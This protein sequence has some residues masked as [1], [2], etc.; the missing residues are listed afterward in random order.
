MI[1]INPMRWIELGRSALQL[2]I[3][4]QLA[5]LGFLVAG[6]VYGDRGFVHSARRGFYVI[7]AALTVSTV[8]LAAAFLSRACYDV[9][10]IAMHSST[11]QEWFYQLAG[12]WA[13]QEGSI[14]F[15]TWI[16]SL[17]GAALAFSLRRDET[18]KMP[19]VLAV[20]AMVQLYF[21]CIVMLLDQNPFKLVPMD[22]LTSAIL[23]LH[24]TEI[25]TGNDLLAWLSLQV[26]GGP[27]APTYRALLSSET[28]ASI[29]AVGG[30]LLP[31]NLSAASVA[32]MVAEKAHAYGFSVLPDGRGLNPLLA[33]YWI[34]IH[35]PAM[36]TGYIGTTVLFAFAIASLIVGEFDGWIKNVRRWLLFCWLFLSVGNILGG[37]WAYEELGWGGFWDWDPVENAAFVPWLTATAMLHTVAA[38]ENRGGFRV[39]NVVLAVMTFALTIWGTWVT[40]S[41]AIASVHAFADG[42]V[43]GA[44]LLGAVGVVIAG[45]TWLIVHRWPELRGTATTATTHR[46][47]Q[48]IWARETMMLGGAITFLIILA[49]V[50]GLTLWPLLTW[51]MDGTS[52]NTR[53]TF[54][55]TTPFFVL[56]FMLMGAATALSWRREKPEA[57]ESKLFLPAMIGA[58]VA[59]LT[60]ALQFQFSDLNWNEFSANVSLGVWNNA[61][62]RALVL[63]LIPPAVWGTTVFVLITTYMEFHRPAVLRARK[64]AGR[65]EAAA[66][67]ATPTPTAVPGYA[68]TEASENSG[69][70]PAVV[71]SAASE[72][73]LRAAVVWAYLGTFPRLIA[74]NRR[75]Y[76]G[77]IAHLGVLILFVAICAATMF[78]TEVEMRDLPLGGAFTIDAG[79]PT[80]GEFTYTLRRFEVGVRVA[81]DREEITSRRGVPATAEKP[82]L[83]IREGA[84]FV[85]NAPEIQIMPD[86]DL[87]MAYFEAPGALGP[88]GQTVDPNFDALLSNVF[89]T[90]PGSQASRMYFPTHRDEAM[91]MGNTTEWRK[92]A[93]YF[94]GRS[95]LELRID[96]PA[97]ELD[98]SLLLQPDA[99]PTEIRLSTEAN[100]LDIALDPIRPAETPTMAYSRMVT[101]ILH[102]VQGSSISVKPV[103]KR[104]AVRLIPTGVARTLSRSTTAAINN[105]ASSADAKPG[106]LEVA[107]TRGRLGITGPMRVEVVPPRTLLAPEVRQYTRTDQTTREA[108]FLVRFFADE[109]VVPIDYLQPIGGVVGAPGATAFAVHHIPGMLWG[110]IGTSILIVGTIVCI[111]PSRRAK[112]AAPSDPVPSP[113]AAPTAPASAATTSAT[114]PAEHHP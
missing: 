7:C 61:T 82:A 90:R 45:T 98:L 89:H 83:V 4:L 75:R 105:G 13:G 110:L 6:I 67:S 10:F 53:E 38:Q 56:I 102:R 55:V 69:P 33:N 65:A 88:A 79:F 28:V 104:A 103:P 37:L 111:W 14:L 35:P 42:T 15:W 31:E 23:S 93:T 19:W 3:P 12:V 44:V 32:T 47:I 49:F 76:G 36:Y 87:P 81:V 59:V 106:F 107:V 91:R 78:K 96:A 77:Y 27:D 20:F 48:T 29:T 41:G 64:A 92:L 80:H 16:L 72:N 66:D 97:L 26:A 2:A 73:R 101:G 94:Y 11:A 71:A 85:P 114:P 25:R 100:A 51:R 84:E 58:A 113:S 109:F 54:F 5:L 60:C 63:P 40:R 62:L 39:W 52:A 18:R 34:A 43:I 8:S 1:D 21:I 17:F 50:I 46:P 30:N 74:A 24:P 57:L 108:A 70:V 86:G 68:P 99:L 9:Q 22:Q 95:W 112:S